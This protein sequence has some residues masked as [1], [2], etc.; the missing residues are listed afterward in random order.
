MSQE[1]NAMK[2]RPSCRPWLAACVAA[3]A[4]AA[5]APAGAQPAPAPEPVVA[6]APEPVVA[7]APAPVAEPSPAPAFEPVAEPAPAPSQ[8]IAELQGNPYAADASPAVV[9]GPLA[10]VV[11][12]YVVIAGGLRFESLQRREGE[13]AQARHPT[14]A[15]SR[16]GVRGR[17]GKHV[18]FVS[19]LEA[20]IGGGLGYGASV[21]EGQA[22]MSV[23]DQL[24]EYDRWGLRVAIGR[25][26]DLATLDFV[27]AHVADLLLTDVY[28]RDPLLYSGFD[29]GTGLMA[30]YRVGDGM[31]VGLTFHSTNPTGLTGT[32][33]I[34]GTLFPFD[35]P[36][37]LAAAQVGRN[38]FTLPDQNL[39][40]Y[41]LT[42][43]FTYADDVLEVKAAAEL[44]Q[45][46]TQ[47]AIA[48][49]E[50]IFGYNFRASVKLALM[51]G[52][53]VPFANA[54]RNENE[55][56]EPMDA[57]LKLIDTYRSHVF[58][59]GVDYNVSG[60]NGVGVQYAQV[61]RNEP[62]V[63]LI[64]DH[65]VNVGATYWLEDSLSLGARVGWFVRDDENQSERYGHRS[66]FLTGRLIL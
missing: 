25:V 4:L 2:S 5:A 65:Y 11:T 62:M 36:F 34:G 42:P 49:D 66:L 6:P 17:V 48:N 57:T 10:K 40:I 22:Q 29:R 28:T 16:L 56:L 64:V 21:W 60:Q 15:V 33:L 38:Q 58:S 61:R 14:V 1:T 32:F 30:R 41:F 54:S 20:N 9:Q 45:L 18:R 44:Y 39:H 7:P 51:A 8:G 12:P 50:R 43:S 63:G 37:S 24:V 59:G 47:M 55:M 26:T 35:R 23:R 46:D 53:L 31:D 27:S 3:W 52:R 19:E 13:T